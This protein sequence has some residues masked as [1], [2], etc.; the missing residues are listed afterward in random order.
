MNYE[1]DGYSKRKVGLKCLSDT[2]Q[3]SDAK[4]E[5]QRE[6]EAGVSSPWCPDEQLWKEQE[7][8]LMLST[9]RGTG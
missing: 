6:G 8:A 5:P 3:R 4:W 2:D 7:A 1:K 9:M